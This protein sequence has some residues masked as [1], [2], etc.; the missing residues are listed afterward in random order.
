MRVQLVIAPHDESRSWT[1]LDDDHNLL[2]PVEKY[3]A[4]LSAIGRSPNTVR[5]YAHDLKD[6]FTYLHTCGLEWEQIQLEDVGRFIPWLGLSDEA[7]QGGA[8]AVP[9]RGSRCSAVTVNRKLSAVSSFYEFHARHGVRLAETM[10]AWQRQGKLAGSWK[11][12]L[13]HLGNNNPVRKRLIALKTD[14]HDPHTLT[15]EQVDAVI[16]ACDRLRDRFLFTLLR[17]S[18][19]RIGEALGIR[20]E[21]LNPRKGEVSV[22]SRI[23]TNHAR[24]KTR[25]RVVPIPAQVFVLY[26]N[27]LHEEYGPLDSDYV[28]VNLWGQPLGEAMNYS[29]VHGL[30]SR[31]RTQTG[32]TFSPHSF[33]HT[34]ATELLRNRVPAEVVRVL[35]GHASISTTVD[36]YAHL[37][38]ED[39]RR[40]LVKAGVL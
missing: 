37:T 30:V 34:Y 2:V 5:A 40:E 36:T 18:G 8:S 7:R 14:Q 29:A 15:T 27:Y 26:S 22:H 3:L 31:I 24:A 39:F 19:L 32:V 11:P 28:F 4:H 38:V 10:T 16:G 20:H 9:F 6:F 23:N 33:R 17:S 25:S 13:A 1:V 12:F 21:D 35:L